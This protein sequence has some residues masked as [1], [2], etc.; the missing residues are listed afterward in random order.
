MGLYNYNNSDNNLPEFNT[1][2]GHF[3]TCYVSKIILYA[4]QHAIIHITY[5]RHI[6]GQSHCLALIDNKHNK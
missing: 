2:H 6:I 4:I 1:L 3:V 5:N